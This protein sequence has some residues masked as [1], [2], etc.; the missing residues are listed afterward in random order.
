MLKCRD[1]DMRTQRAK[2]MAQGAE[3]TE[4][5]TD[6]LHVESA[7]GFMILLEGVIENS[8]QRSLER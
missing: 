8:L 7:C 4:V 3:G 5:E 6:N 1:A 2:G